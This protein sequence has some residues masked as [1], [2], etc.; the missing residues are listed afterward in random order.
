M[1]RRVSGMVKSLLRDESGQT[2]L[3]YVVIVIFVVIVMFFAFR[4][5]KGIISRSIKKASHSIE[6]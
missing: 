2:K 3:E 1:A 5:A 4:L 6:Q